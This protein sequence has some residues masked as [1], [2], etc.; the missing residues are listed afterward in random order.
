MKQLDLN[1]IWKMRR[2]TAPDMTNNTAV[3]SSP[4][5][6]V[7]NV[8]VNSAA[9]NS[10]AG[11]AAAEVSAN[12]ADAEW[13]DA[14]VPGSV[15]S[16]LLACGRMPDPYLADNER[17][18]LPI[19]DHDF[20]FVRHFT[21]D[22]ALLAHD[23]VLLHCD[24]LDTLCDLL[25][26]GTLF[27]SC[28]N[29]HR[30]WIFDVKSL[31]REG[32]NTLSLTFHSAA[33]YVKAH[34]S[35]VGKPYSVIR[36]A[37][38]MF[39]WDWG[40]ALPDMG[41][42]RDIYLETF[43]AARLEHLQVEQ[44]HQENGAVEL[45]LSVT[46]ENW[47]KASLHAQV[48]SPDGEILFDGAPDE[49]GL[50]SL[51]IDTPQLWWP[52]GYG[53]QPLYTVCV[54][55]EKNGV[56]CD[57]R[58]L[59]IGLRTIVLDRSPEGNGSRYSFLVNGVPVFFRGENLIIPDAILSRFDSR[60]WE[61]IVESA[62]SS[63]VN[64]LRVWGGAIYPSDRFYE[65]CDEAGILLFH[66]L[67]F[68]CS[69]YE[70]SPDFLENVRAETR[71]NLRRIAHHA[72]LALLCGNNEIDAIYTVSGSSDPETAALRVMFGSGDPLP[73][74]TLDLLWA[75]Y[76]PLFCK[77][78][79]ALC[80][81][82]APDTAYV[83]SSPC[84][85]VP[86][87]AQS[88][89]D[90][91]DDGDMHYYLQYNDNAPYQKMRQFRCRF[92]TEMGF[93]SY[94]SLKTLRTFADEASLS[95]YSPVMLA[96][97]KCIRGNETIELYMERDYFVPQEFGD[98][99]YLSQLQAGEILKYSVEHFRRDA[100]YCRGVILW[101]QGD[102]WPVVSW[103][104]IDYCGRW[105]AQQYYIRRF[106]APVLLSVCE[107]DRD[108]AFW[109]TNDTPR[110]VNAT[111]RWQLRTAAGDAIRG[112]EAEGSVAPGEAREALRIPLSLTQEERRSHVLTYSLWENGRMLCEGS[113]LLCLAKEFAW[114][115]PQLSL[116]VRENPDSYEITVA[117]DC[118][119]KGVCL[120]TRTGD[121]LFSD[122]FFD[123]VP[124]SA[125][126]TTVARKDAT[127]ISSA[128]ELRS[129]LQAVTLGDVLLRAQGT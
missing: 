91:M 85:S 10:S 9:A 21:A 104:G 113:T 17:K 86:G 30:T 41:I 3:S 12:T 48:F 124:D 127:G 76:R 38:C 62:L 121:C 74:E 7:P 35:R 65:L 117:A 69:F 8:S 24:G 80:R 81:T 106:Y 36:K 14:A 46:A 95:P 18:V 78:L 6:A 13:L 110:A 67:M 87:S 57:S 49:N 111:V 122:N 120:D 64:A 58:T 83:T 52:V 15:A 50:C 32:E 84:G 90:Y 26:N 128:D 4:D 105:K 45:T 56:L 93:Q 16:A 44:R 42:W 129:V 101:Q 88:F 107:S 53:G 40:L 116:N 102:C 66:D 108:A 33:A 5:S 115:R 79:P 63:N 123:L 75:M 39:G 71:D 96:H 73:R 54:T 77:L 51:S 27:A 25:L 114:R 100:S 37:A 61:R 109:I 98:Y 72:C 29:M 118:Y 23:Q 97:Q 103:S 99:V 34:P 94:P 11:T 70:I 68:A 119:A 89:F 60:G 28:D 112:G 82:C 2:L 55:A 22:R 125:R 20:E 59:R 19:F 92:M 31:L 126:V 43:D 47:N 1:G